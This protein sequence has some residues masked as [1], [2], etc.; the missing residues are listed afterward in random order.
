MYPYEEMSNLKNQSYISSFD[1]LP[2]H[3]KIQKRIV[4]EN[5]NMLEKMFQKSS[6]ICK[7]ISSSIVKTVAQTDIR[8]NSYGVFRS[9]FLKTAQKWTKNTVTIFPDIGLSYRFHDWVSY[10]ST[11]VSKHQTMYEAE[12]FSIFKSSLPGKSSF[13]SCWNW[14][15]KIIFQVNF[16]HCELLISISSFNPPWYISMTI[17]GHLHSLEAQESW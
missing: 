5:M 16:P 11:D 1:L 3:F 15:K 12:H 2:Q 14:E 17:S 6:K 4:G 10:N 8:K 9:F 7:N 13:L